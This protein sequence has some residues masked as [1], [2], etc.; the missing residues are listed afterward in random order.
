MFTEERIKLI[1][2]IN[3]FLI[4]FLVII[5]LFPLALSK[6]ETTATG[7]IQSNIAFYLAKA[8]YQTNN[9]KLTELKPSPNPYVYTFTV[10]NQD[11][12]KISEVDIEYTLKIITTT[13]LPLRYLLYKNEDYQSNESTNLVTNNNT[14][15][16]P[17]DDGTYFKTITFNKEELLYTTPKTN[18]YTLVIYYDETDKNSKYQDTVESIRIVVDSRQIID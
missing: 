7:N 8:G 15:I 3:I 1:F 10:G 11:G 17:D 6:Y 18:N 2:K 13:N 12:T 14:V 4:T 16:E 9:I 5:I